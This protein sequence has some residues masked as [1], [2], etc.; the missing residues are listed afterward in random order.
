MI[1]H[2]HGQQV[3]LNEPVHTGHAARQRLG[4]CLDGAASRQL[5]PGRDLDRSASPALADYRE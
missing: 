4:G 2:R 3:V 5:R 1:G